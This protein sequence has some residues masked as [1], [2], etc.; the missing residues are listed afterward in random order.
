MG[1]I[2]LLT[3]YKYK[4]FYLAKVDSRIKKHF[5]GDS[6]LHISHDV[7]NFELPQASYNFNALLEDFNT[8]AWHF[9]FVNIHY[10]ENYKIIIAQ[11]KNHGT[12]VTPDNGLLGL[13]EVE[14]ESFY[15]L[16]IKPS[17]F[18]EL[19]IIDAC[20][21]KEDLF[22]QLEKIE[23]PHFFRPITAI[24]GEKEIKGEIIYIDGY[25]NCISNINKTIFD[26]FTKGNSYHV[27]IR[28]ER[29]ESISSD[30]SENREAG[31][32]VFFNHQN[33]LEISTIHGNA[34][35]LLG[36]QVGSRISIKLN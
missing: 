11:T 6:L 30:Y 3:D 1:L 12:I 18:P 21:T 2:T 16:T 8:N 26:E 25:G 5:V 34:S 19:S 22:T 31:I 33:H 32:A 13:L 23:K 17:S 9:I 20:K 29:I 28:R 15:S 24:V 10:A 4:D 27:K 14:F 35:K 7:R 36:L